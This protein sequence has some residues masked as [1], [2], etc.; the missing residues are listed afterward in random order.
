MPDLDFFVLFSSASALLGPPRLAAYAAANS[1][2]DALAHARRGTGQHA[3]SINW[4]AWSEVGMAARFER[5]DVAAHAERGMGTLSTNEALAAFEH[6]LGLDTAQVAVLPV[7]WKRW[8]QLYPALV[9]VPLFTRF[10]ERDS[11]AEGSVVANRGR[12]IHAA[13][14]GERAA[15]VEEYLAAMAAH[16]LG[17]PAADLDRDQPLSSFGLDSLMAVE[18]KNGI[19]TELGVV[20]PMVSFLEGRTTVELGAQVVSLLEQAATEDIVAPDV[21]ALSEAE[22][23]RLLEQLLAGEAAS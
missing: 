6:V 12:A 22:V 20:V 10:V 5:G 4:G 7:D 21:D 11:H 18:L 9:E 13:R 15:L 14:G 16:V 19:E 17:F 3:L 1:Y 8:Q 2:M 23:D